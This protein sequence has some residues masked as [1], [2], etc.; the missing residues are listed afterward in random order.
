MARAPWYRVGSR[1]GGNPFESLDIDWCSRCKMEVDTDTIAEH[2]HGVYVYKR[3]CCRCGKVVK[4]GRYH[5]PLVSDQSLPA[6][7]TE[8]VTAPGEVKRRKWAGVE[9]VSSTQK[10]DLNV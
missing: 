8:W 2:R 3:W 9:I 4:Y 6:A 1:T 10:G 5:A 7:A